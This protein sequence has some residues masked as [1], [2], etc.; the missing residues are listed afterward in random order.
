MN[1]DSR[2]I[3]IRGNSG[4]GKSTVARKLHMALVRNTLIISQDIVRRQMLYVRDG[5]DTP[6]LSLLADL[7]NYGHIHCRHIILEGI[8]PIGMP[9]YSNRL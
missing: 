7:L 4:S 9:P 5:Q 3:I 6:A 8:I 2:L 1:N